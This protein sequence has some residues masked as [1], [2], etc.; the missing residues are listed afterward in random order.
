MSETRVQ[1]LVVEDS[2]DQA[3]LLRKYFE[4]AGCAVTT[5]E[6]AE[7]AILA[8]T[9]ETPDLAVIDLQLPGM[10]GWELAGRLKTDRPDC[11]IA[12]TSVL[13]AA[14]FPAAEAFLPKPF[15]GAQV[16]QVLKDTVPKWSAK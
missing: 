6:T 10:D 15:T 5:V 14:D 4:R 16:R 9:A 3:G 2:E 8:Y 11:A 7:Q 13:D 12:I 1:V